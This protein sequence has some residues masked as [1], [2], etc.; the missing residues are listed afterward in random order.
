MSSCP[1][2]MADW[3]WSFTFLAFFRQAG[4]VRKAQREANDAV[5]R[6]THERHVRL[7]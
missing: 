5:K 3:I 2:W 1:R 4:D 7:R 6:H